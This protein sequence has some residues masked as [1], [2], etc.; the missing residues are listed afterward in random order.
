MDKSLV[1]SIVAPLHNAAEFVGPFL[2]RLTGVLSANYTFYEIIL[3]DDSSEDATAAAVGDL[4]KKHD[5]VRFLLLS[6]AYGREIAVAAGLESASGEFV[7]TLDAWTDPVERIPQLVDKCRKGSGILCGIS[8]NPR[9]P[10]LLT[11]IATGAFHGYCR[12]FLAFDYKE[13]STDFRVLSRQAVNAVTRIRDRHRYLRVFA[14]TLGYNQEFFTYEQNQPLSSGES[15]MERIDHALEIAI[16]NSRH[17][18]RV[19]SRIGLGLS[20]LNLLYAFYVLL[21]FLFKRDVAAGW[22]T[23]SMQMTG[24]FFFLFL[25][26]AVLC[27]YV[28]RILEETQDRPLYFVSAERTSSVLLENSIEKNILNEAKGS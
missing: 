16:A 4:L 1:V 12:K 6:R 9:A 21:I 15:L 24:M 18:L 3:V 19:V 17:P 20:A 8:S 27:E 7:V 23:M 5:R 26:L 25:I 13:D 14:A 22:T 11:R 2:E 28:G 10:G